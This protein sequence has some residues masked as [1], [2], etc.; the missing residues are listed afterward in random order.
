MVS[1]LFYSVVFTFLAVF[2]YTIAHD[3]VTAFLDRAL[4]LLHMRPFGR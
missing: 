4:D 3:E 2:L 1:I